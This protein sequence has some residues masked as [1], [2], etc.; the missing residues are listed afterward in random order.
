M[1]ELVSLRGEPVQLA[2]LANVTSISAGNDVL[3]VYAQTDKSVELRTGNGWAEQTKGVL[4]P[5]FAG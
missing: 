3:S 4:M 2:P 1:V 5:S